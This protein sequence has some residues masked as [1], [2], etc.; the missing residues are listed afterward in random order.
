MDKE[1]VFEQ[2]QE[3]EAFIFSALTEKYGGGKYG[4]VDFKSSDPLY[5]FDLI[6][7][8][9]LFISSNKYP[10]DRFEKSMLY[11]FDV[12]LE[13]YYLLEVD[14][15]SLNSRVIDRGYDFAN[16]LN[17]PHLLM[18]K[19][20]INQNVIIKSRIL[21][22]R[23]MNFIYYIETGVDL[24]S[25]VSGKKSKTKVF[26]QY[27][28][29]RECLDFLIKYKE[30]ISEFDEKFRT[31]EVHKNSIFRAEVLGNRSIDVWEDN[32]MLNIIN[33]VQ[34]NLWENIR[35]LVIKQDSDK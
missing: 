6:E 22:E 9:N 12:K 24:E 18:T 5:R 11:L 2:I 31:P 34:S 3:F 14:L 17:T 28:S 20:S 15:G 16:P 21:W 4:S 27:C 7:F 8:G 23:L 29:Q 25:K 13:W 1:S 26:F 33:I 19:Y 32:Q 10:E 30:K 35:G